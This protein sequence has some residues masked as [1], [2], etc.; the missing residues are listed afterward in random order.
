[1]EVMGARLRSDKARS[2]AAQ[3]CA[4]IA[5]G[6]AF[7]AAVG[8]LLHRW[9]L[10]AFTYRYIP[11]APLTV[12]T[13]MLLS[14]AGFLT[15]R[16][17][18]QR[19]ACR[20]SGIFALLVFLLGLTILFQ[21][22][23]YFKPGIEDLLS[24]TSE[25]LQGAPLG[26]MSP[27]TASSL[28]LA[29]L[30]LFF[31]IASSEKKKIPRETS[32]FL[33]SCEIA[34]N[35]VVLMGYACNTPLLYGGKIIPVALPTAICF[36]LL[37][38]GSLM[39]AGPDVWLERL[40]SGSSLQARLLR[41]F[42]PA[43]M[44][45]EL[46]GGWLNVAVL[47]HMAHNPAL[48]ESIRTLGSAALLSLLCMVIARWIGGDVDRAE[49]ALRASE[50]RY[51]ILVEH[52][53]QR[54]FLKD[55]NSTYM[56]CNKVMARDLGIHSEEICG[57][58]DF[59]FFP[60]SL[61]DKYRLDDIL[62]MDSGKTTD[63]EELYIE[64]GREILV[65]T[66]KTPVRD[67][68]G[69][70]VGI[71]GI[72]WDITASKHAERALRESEQRFR[73]ILEG[74]H[75]AA[76][77]L[78]IKGNIAFC[79]NY[80]LELTDRERKEILGKNWVELFVPA[81]VR[82]K[83]GVAFHE[84]MRSGSVPVHLENDIMTRSGELRRIFWTN[85]IMRD[86]EGQMTG[87]TSL[88]ENV[89][90]RMQFES[91]LR[92]AQKMEAIGTLAGGIAHD[93][94]NILAAIMGYTEM[95]I[96]GIS[97]GS[98]IKRNLDQVLAASNR[99]KDLVKQILLFSR[100]EEQ[101]LKPIQLAPIVKEAIKLLRAS[102]PTTIEI[103]TNIPASPLSLVAADPTQIHQILIN[104]CTNAGHAMRETGGILEVTL[105]D[106][107]IDAVTAASHPDL[108]PGSY[109]RL[110]VGDT[111]Q[112]IDSCI[113]DRIFDPF[114]TT[115]GPREGTGMGL[116]V[117]HGIVRNYDGAISVYSEPGRGTIFHV[118]FPKVESYV[119]SVLEQ[120][121]IIPTGH[122]RILFVDDEEPL[123]GLGQRLLERLGYTVVAQTS[124]LEALKIFEK[125]P[126]H[127]D[128]VISDYTMPHMTGVALARA[129]M[130]VRP[131]IPVI[132]CTG[133]SETITEE[134]AKEMGIREFLMKPLA[135]RQ[136]AEIISKILNN[137]KE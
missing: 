98:S 115:K 80:L 92:Q 29:G 10:A 38:A 79:N 100:K 90:E 94:N 59:D 63:I 122:G 6:V 128:L 7:T 86:G 64:N 69:S 125:H 39:M 82:T 55:R 102:L 58:T 127:F 54:I 48:W 93:F 46:L 68:T 132:L 91:R 25:V 20:L 76:V 117:V 111:G 124:S 106:T 21:W 16:Y 45:I 62:V 130:S 73:E 118:Y 23:G 50:A 70:T 19:W 113:R 35:A 135:I 87:M 81:E 37:G 97:E 85:T 104:L 61:A 77:I 40:L 101:E 12:L 65:R 129:M 9:D 14:G 5:A 13:I 110:S 103:R 57:K 66:V 95:S 3:L 120:T 108:K 105:R 28:V 34:V 41:A 47:R 36:V 121:R 4:G 71:L 67:E 32:A 137:S 109:L 75:M 24:R 18:G 123:A 56:S 119:P 112:G 84:S 116:A 107:E 134:K 8:W 51:R 42:L 88:G 72:F 49:S 99:A 43:V 126:Y 27:L 96:L 2:R 15:A 31:L 44:F 74:V 83:A 26:R 131:D 30:S 22:L 11:M 1:M 53:P 17:P 33:S 89:S 133:F 136:L 60:P 114:F 52:L 78:D